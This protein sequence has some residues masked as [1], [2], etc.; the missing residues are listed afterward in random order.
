[1]L[2]KMRERTQSLTYKIIVGAL[3]FVLAVFGFGAFNFFISPDPAVATV[4]GEDIPQS[5]LEQE[6]ERR[7]RMLLNQLGENADPDLIDPL[8]IQASTLEELV[9]RKLIEQASADMGIE[10]SRLQVD[11][12]I[13]STPDFQVGGRYDENTYL[14]LLRSAGYTPMRYREITR[15]ALATGQLQ[16]AFTDTAVLFPWERTQAAELTAQT[17]DVAYLAVK[18]EDVEDDLEVSAEEID[19]HYQANQPDYMTEESVAV[20]YVSLSLDS[21]EAQPEHEPAE[22]DIVARY[23]A[24][25]EEFVAVEQR[26][27]S[28]ILVEVSD[29]R[30]E[31]AAREVIESAI[32]RLAA[33]ETF[34]ALAEEL[35]DDP[36][37]KAQGGDLGL[38][39]RGVYVGPFEDALFA[40]A[41][42][43][44]LSE[45]VVTE[46][47][48]HLIRLDGIEESRYPE[49]E[50]QREALVAEL[51][52]ESASAA[53]ADAARLLDEL[54]FDSPESLDV[55]VED[56]GLEKLTATGVTRSSGPG[57]FVNAALRNAAFTAEV[58]NEGFNSGAVAI[59]DETSVVLRV[60]EVTPAAL[61]PLADVA[62]TIRA[63]LLADAAALKVE[64]RIDA[65]L[66]SLNAGE[67]SDVA[68]TA[69]GVEWQRAEAIRRTATDA[70]REVLRAAFELPRPEDGERSVGE[71]DLAGGGRAAVVVTKV[72][73]GDITALPE[74]EATVIERQMQRRSGQLEF[75]GFYGGIQEA[76]SVRRR[77]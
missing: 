27:A 75:E 7:R 39:P 12:S 55:I 18:P 52:R 20:E 58:M 73:D 53:Y 32:A 29:E 15:S 33:G 50:E 22:T 40:L 3:I 37:S 6:S 21:I 9:N 59:N 5:Q 25:R 68:A 34:A 47:G 30:D 62:D 54:A 35:S 17:R 65:A 14:M 23:D 72:Y 48:V 70:P 16:R 2:Q 49:L 36:G 1:M 45:P 76:A 10:V 46:F 31:S 4:N 13:T 43:G 24:N 71:A 38:A 8:A 42:P 57:V 67:D 28:H 64:E 51:R 66:A 19:A 69:A 56:L 74:S 60:T 63:T 26:R 11:R 61:R 77:I 44:E 41:A